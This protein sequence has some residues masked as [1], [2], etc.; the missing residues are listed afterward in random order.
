MR[1]VVQTRFQRRIITTRFTVGRMRGGRTYRRS[2]EM[3]TWAQVLWGMATTR[4]PE[5]GYAGTVAHNV[6]IR[7]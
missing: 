7:Y 2:Q 5:V 1:M 3:P 4:I 6:R